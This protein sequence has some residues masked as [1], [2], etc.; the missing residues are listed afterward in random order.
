MTKQEEFS[1]EIIGN[2]SSCTIIEDLKLIDVIRFNKIVR[3]LTIPSSYFTQNR[4][5]ASHDSTMAKEEHKRFQQ[6]FNRLFGNG[7][8][9]LFNNV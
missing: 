4:K 8:R 6:Y 3:E 1:Y 2:S 9:S 7:N 5:E